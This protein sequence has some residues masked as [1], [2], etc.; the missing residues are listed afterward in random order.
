M[1]RAGQGGVSA[2]R[3]VNTQN[4]ATIG[5]LSGTEILP[6]STT[7]DSPAARSRI[8]EPGAEIFARCYLAQ[9]AWPETDPRLVPQSTVPLGPEQM[10]LLTS[11]AEN[12]PF[13]LDGFKSARRH[14]S[15][16]EQ[17]H[18]LLNHDAFQFQAKEPFRAEPLWKDRIQRAVEAGRPVELVYPLFTKEGCAA[19]IMDASGPTGA[20]WIT[21]LFFRHLNELARQ[22]YPPGLVL[23]VLCDALLYNSAYRNSPVEAAAYL[24]ELRSMVLAIS[25]SPGIQ[26]HDYA[27]LLGPFR[28]KFQAVYHE[29]HRRLREDPAAV[30]PREEYLSLLK[31]IR[32]NINTRPMGLDY[33]ELKAVFGPVQDP[34]HPA[35]EEVTRMAQA[36]LCEKLA[37][38]E[39]AYATQAIDGLFP[40]ALRCTV[41]K[42]LKQGRAVLGLRTYPEY[43][44][45][46]RILPYHGVARL[47]SDGNRWK[48]TVLPEIMLRGRPELTRVLSRDGTTSFYVE[49]NQ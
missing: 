42:G 20:E 19:K 16:H 24:T 22:I 10:A 12:I 14:Q 27:E 8:Y 40:Q 13:R 21:L 28:A 41:H 33:S 31:S 32:A 15:C 2:G 43:Y 26:V 34:S 48:A 25:V 6:I 36:A 3:G 18:G 5:P 17:L 23:H 7:N 47:Q 29:T 35:W 1:R 38:K 45:S 37:I 11:A 30:I 49:S 46:S 39:A 44:R 4:L 9:A